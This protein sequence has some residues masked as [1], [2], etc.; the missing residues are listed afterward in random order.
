MGDVRCLNCG[1]PW[2]AYY[3][4]HDCEGEE[5]GFEFGSSVL[6]VKRCPC[7][8]RRHSILRDQLAR[9]REKELELIHD[10]LGDDEDGLQTELEDYFGMEG[11]DAD[12]W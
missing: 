4:R 2:D 6:I 5:E 7:C 3:L 9:K 1:E 10:L 8:P 11:E 12:L